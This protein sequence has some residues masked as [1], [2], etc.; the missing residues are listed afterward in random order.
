[1]RDYVKYPS[2]KNIP[3]K[4][5][6][7]SELNEYFFDS[8]S[9]NSL[10]FNSPNAFNDPYE[11]LLVSNF[12]KNFEDACKAELKNTGICCLSTKKDSLHL[13]SFYAKALKG[14][15][16]EFNRDNLISGLIESVSKKENSQ[17]W[18]YCC[19]VNY[20]PKCR[21]II[22]IV[23]QDKIL[24]ADEEEYIK[25]FA[26]KHKIFQEESEIRFLVRPKPGR[27][28]DFSPMVGHLSYGPLAVNKII[29]G[30]EVK[31][32]EIIEVRRYFPERITFSRAEL[33]K[34]E[35]KIVIT[36]II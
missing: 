17:G 35:Y 14:V 22:P 36:P 31:T 3:R 21:P 15:C 25:Y 7:Y 13:W 18:L 23:H 24:V 4:L 19:T 1:M 28:E 26:T 9:K 11:P 10:F 30:K 34:K 6:K 2:K 20:I 33:S 32:E 16:I 27:Y 5:Y 12:E 29:F 8:I